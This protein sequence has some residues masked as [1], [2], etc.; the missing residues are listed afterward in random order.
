MNQVTK[1]S[2]QLAALFWAVVLM[3]PLPGFA[4]Y[5]AWMNDLE[6]YGYVLPL[7][8][9]L[10]ALV[11]FRWD[12]Q[13]R[14]PTSPWSFA[15]VIV[16]LVATV[17][18]AWSTTPWLSAVG[19]ALGCFAWLGSHE[20]SEKPIQRLTYLGVL[21]LMLIRL[22]L[23]LDV[24]LASGLQRL[25]SRVSGAVLDALGVTHYLRGNVI[26]LPGGTLFVEEAC[27]GA[28]SLFTVLF[29]V[30]LWFSFRRRATVTLPVYLVFGI[31]WAM[32]MNVV[33][34]TTVALAQEWF[35]T[36]L[37]SGLPHEVLG[38]ICLLLAVLMVMST[39][40]GLRVAFFPVPP[41]DTGNQSNPVARL[42]NRSLSYGVPQE[43]SEDDESVP[44]ELSW[45]GRPFIFRSTFACC[46]IACLVSLGLSYGM[47]LSRFGETV[48]TAERPLLWE[49]A[50][51]LLEETSF[52][53]TVT[54]HEV[55]RDANSKQL[56]NHADIWTVVVEGM[57][58][59]VAISQPYPE[60][61]DMRLCYTGDGWQV[62]Q[63]NPM[64]EDLGSGKGEWTISHAEMI[65]ETGQYGT[66]LFS[67]ISNEGNLLDP[68]MLGIQSLL[69]NRMK[70]RRG[71]SSRTIMLQLWTESMNPL[72]QKQLSTLVDLFEAF[73]AEALGNLTGT[74]QPELQARSGRGAAEIRR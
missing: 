63:W 73:R 62:N 51:D 12:Y 37:S 25:T 33:R 19:L 57:V 42:W 53:K 50:A 10:V 9:S 8:I 21:L 35:S 16:S 69:G 3:A 2:R 5:L 41:D 17:L 1:S 55:L 36:D 26:E 67:G 64:I 46:G 31:G 56:G 4:V 20:S 58:V 38:W 39:D 71:L 66:L 22:P 61:H 14:V 68:P 7:L 59:R 43:V 74:R 29:L 11:L 24:W 70:D 40:R 13:L 52:G 28:Q 18:A 72:T 15:V 48:R 30:C 45:A 27:S 47:V 65:E 44:V 49:P 23:N 54:S 60:W 34:I 6:Q 32:V